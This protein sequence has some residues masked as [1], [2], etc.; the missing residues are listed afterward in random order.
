[1]SFTGFGRVRKEMDFGN[2]IEE[3]N[4]LLSDGAWYLSFSWELGIRARTRILQ[5][6]NKA[7]NGG[8]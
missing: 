5:E 6:R 2:W 4:V 1:M 3:R 8:S 7:Q